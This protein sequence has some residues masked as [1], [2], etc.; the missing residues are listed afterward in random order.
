M[1]TSRSK[2][3]FACSCCRR[4]WDLIADERRRSGNEKRERQENGLASEEKVTKA[5][6]EAYMARQ[7]IRTPLKFNPD[8][9]DRS[10]ECAPGWAAG[11]AFNASRGIPYVVYE[12]AAKA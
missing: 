9:T 5:I 10:P 6:F 1:E 3:L 7:E 4:I 12:F 8:L 11:A 2:K